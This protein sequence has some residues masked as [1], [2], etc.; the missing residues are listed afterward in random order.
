MELR[1]YGRIYY[2][3]IYYND[4]LKMNITL[5][6]FEQQINKNIM[7][8]NEINNLCYKQGNTKTK[9]M[10]IFIICLIICLCYELYII[11]NENKSETDNLKVVQI[12]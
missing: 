6:E 9:I 3:E 11:Y 8:E 2:V 1:K 5:K 7:S 4:K 12:A 10:H